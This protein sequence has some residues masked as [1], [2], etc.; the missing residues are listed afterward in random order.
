[1]NNYSR[2]NNR[3]ID[4]VA[5]NDFGNFSLLPVVR[6]FG[7]YNIMMQTAHDMSRTFLQLLLVVE[8]RKYYE[9][10]ITMPLCHQ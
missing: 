10:C 7:V 4:L 3:F 8:K 2:N 9:I 6:G 5:D 1:V